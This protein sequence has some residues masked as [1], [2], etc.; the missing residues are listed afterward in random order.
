MAA[1][2]F[3]QPHLLGIRGLKKAEISALLTRAEKYVEGNRRGERKLSLLKGATIINLFYEG[4]TRT[5]TSFELAGKRLGADVVNI[6]VEHSSVKKGES[7]LDTAMTISAMHAD[8]IVIRHN[9]SGAP[10]FLAGKIPSSII[11]AGDGCHEHPTQALLDALTIKRRKGKIAGLKIAICGDIKHSRVARSNALLLTEMGA[12]VHFIAPPTLMP[13]GV[14]SLGVTPHYSMEK[15]IKKADIVMMLRIQNERMDSQ[16]ISTM[17]EYFACYGLDENKMAL[18]KP[19]ALVLHPGPINRGVEI[20]SQ[21]ADCMDRS[22][23]LE[24]VEMGVA[25]RQAVLESL[26]EGRKK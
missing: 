5:R 24:Q 8:F 19:D 10:H 26:F 9:H 17:R 21:V 11:N 13:A 22:V 18:A 16:Y 20:A 14:E 7:L 12:D 6:S 15:G 4:S 1:I 3:S 2:K 25:V 23:I